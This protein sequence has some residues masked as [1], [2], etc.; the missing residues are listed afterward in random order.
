MTEMTI[1]FWLASAVLPRSETVTGWLKSQRLQPRWIDEVI[2]L[3]ESGPENDLDLIGLEPNVPEFRWN[4]D[5]VN[6]QFIFHAACREVA[7][8]DRNLILLLSGQSRQTTAVL[9]ASPAAV[10][11]YNL[12]PEAYVEE[13]IS[14][15]LPGTEVE[16][17]PI[18][19]SALLK[20]QRKP[21]QLKA[22]CLVNA[23]GKRPV[24]AE[25]AFASAGWVKPQ[26]PAAGA[27]AACHELVGALAQ[28]ELT[29]GLA[30]E[31]TAAGQLFATWIERV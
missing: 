8:D 5:Q 16:L 23:A 1:P 17:F 10:G 19:E 28:K 20:K 21:A 6:E 29:N 9:L 13:L 14:L 3:T 4:S 27:L 11:M 7:V 18:L 31:V 22:I 25:T 15:R 2:R 26:N 30:A 12:I 24:K